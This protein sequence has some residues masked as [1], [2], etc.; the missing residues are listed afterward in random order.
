MAA[1]DRRHLL[2]IA[3]PAVALPMVA[4]GA[5]AK[6]MRLVTR[7]EIMEA[8]RFFDAMELRAGDLNLRYQILIDM[9]FETNP[10]TLRAKLQQLIDNRK[11]HLVLVDASTGQTAPFDPDMY[12]ELGRKNAQ[13][14]QL[15][16]ERIDAAL[17]PV[18]EQL[19]QVLDTPPGERLPGHPSYGSTIAEMLPKPKLRYRVAAWLMGW[20]A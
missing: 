11:D 4:T 16:R 14:E 18:Q 12:V 2:R 17:A 7:D 19:Q 1:M 8:F 15:G 5:Q 3:A 13:M 20:R 10:E 6:E 9:L